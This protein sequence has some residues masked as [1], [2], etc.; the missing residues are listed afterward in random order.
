MV[1][2]KDV[3]GASIDA[4]LDKIQEICPIF[5]T[6]Y[7]INDKLICD[8]DAAEAEA[9][10]MGGEGFSVGKVSVAVCKGKGKGKE[11]GG[12]EVSERVFFWEVVFLR[13]GLR[14]AARTNPKSI[15][16]FARSA[17]FCGGMGNVE[18]GVV[19]GGNVIENICNEVYKKL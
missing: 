19:G 18:L 14:S 11:G 17:Q 7:S 16:F 13:C 4:G 3:R 8:V 10:H 5:V 15:L 6:I 9:L 2:K 1:L 12:L